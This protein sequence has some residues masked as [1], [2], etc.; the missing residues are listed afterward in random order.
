[1]GRW[2]VECGMKK[3]AVADTAAVEKS[4]LILILNIRHNCHMTGAFDGGCESSLVFRTVAGNPSGKDFST[5]GY[6]SF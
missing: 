1:M 6:I 2:G 4:S 5:L 3:T